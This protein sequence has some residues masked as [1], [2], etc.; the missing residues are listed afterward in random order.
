MEKIYLRHNLPFFMFSIFFFLFAVEPA[1]EK[2]NIIDYIVWSLI[3]L[4]G[5]IWLVS[6]IISIVKNKK[7]FIISFASTS[8]F[9]FFNIASALIGL[10][11]SY[12]FNSNL[13]K[14]WIFLLVI[15][16]VA[17]LIPNPFKQK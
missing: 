15:Y 9:S 14:L 5:A 6:C 1:L 10:I 13:I 7:N 8:I 11:I 17:I 12:F 4:C 3:I 16:I 2:I